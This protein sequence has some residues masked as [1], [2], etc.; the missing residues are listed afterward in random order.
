[1]S[2]IRFLAGAGLA[3]AAP[4]VLAQSQTPGLWEQTVRMK[5][6]DGAMERAQ[7]QMQQQLAAMPPEQRKMVEEAMAKNNVTMGPQGTTLR[8]CLTKEQAGRSPRPQVNGTDCTFGEPKRSGNTYKYSYACA[9][10]T[11]TT[12]VGEFTF[13]GDKSYKGTMDI[14]SETP[15]GPSRMTMQIAARWLA[16]DCGMVKPLVR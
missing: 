2:V 12:G 15:D 6:G 3:L 7:A 16:A 5:T 13:D 1:M 4:Y 8:I 10:P 14:A 11:R 9:Q